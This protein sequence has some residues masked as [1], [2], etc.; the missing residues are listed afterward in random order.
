[1]GRSIGVD[2]GD[3]S[4]KAVELD[5]SYRKTRLLRC[6]VERVAAEGLATERVLDAAGTIAAVL[7]EGRMGGELVLGLPCREAVLRTVNLPFS[8]RDAIRRVIKSEVEN[9]IFSH[10]VDDMVVDFHELG[11]NENGAR[12]LV[13]AVPK[14]ALRGL[15]EALEEER[16]EPERVDLDTMALYRVADWA[17]AFDGGR[18]AAGDGD[19]GPED[20]EEF[21]LEEAA[22]AKPASPAS[23]ASADLPD[24]AGEPRLTAV[25]DLGARS[26]RVLLVQGRQLI[27]MR[28]LRFG[29]ASVAEAVA[30][31]Q[32]VPLET[33][34]EALA[35]C[36]ATGGDYEAEIPAELPEPV[37]EAAPEVPAAAE[38]SAAVPS[39]RR[40][41]VTLAEVRSEQTAFLQRLAREL[42][43]FLTAAGVEGR[44]EA[45]WITGGASR[46]DGMRE[47][48]G[49]VFGVRPLELDVMGRLRHNLPDEE[50][51]ELGPRIA[52]AVG[53]ALANYGGPGSFNFRQEDLAYTRGFDRVKFPLAITCMVALFTA[54]VYGVKLKN[55]LQNLEFRH[56]LTYVGPEADPNR[57][58]FFGHLNAVVTLAW[59]D[60]DRYFRT[61]DGARDY[62]SRELK[63]DL[64]GKPVHERIRF[65]RDRLRRVLNLKQEESGI[66]ED[67]V[68][69]S[70]LAVLERFFA[71]LKGAEEG[72]GRYLLTEFELGM[73]ATGR[74][75]RSGRSLRFTVAFRG[76]EFRIRQAALRAALQKE[77]DEHPGQPF[78]L[79]KE[80][81]PEQVYDSRET[82]VS[83]ASY[84]LELVISE[85]FDAIAIGGGS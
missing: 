68:L 24:A 40:F 67:V 73:R 6:R 76:D 2:V 83:G 61:P 70:G 34:R 59:W 29:E 18:S 41:E 17:G 58:Q 39:T 16:V 12:V 31:R 84:H 36:L 63:K 35:A 32:Q 62:G 28:T 3:H 9:A 75:D 11:K 60:E 48:L 37:G 51:R 72:T 65:V 4:I 7:K 77:I 8:G 26:T 19:G 23:P 71:V 55:E 80:W 25:L 78:L 21:A 1:M 54:V 50:A 64:V 53:L 49:E 56:G 5:G 85:A 42:V 33:A 66:Y 81:K 44:F 69:E 52:V 38:G 43:R 30:R 27:D 79:L 13:A 15:L 14:P 20:A 74:G 57:P 10:S 46:M 47:M 45:L 82:G 22:E